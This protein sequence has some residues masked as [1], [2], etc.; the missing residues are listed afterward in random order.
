[1]EEVIPAPFMFCSETKDSENLNNNTRKQEDNNGINNRTNCKKENEE[2]SV[3]QI[4]SRENQSEKLKETVTTINM[5]CCSGVNDANILNDSCPRQPVYFENA[6][7]GY[8]SQIES[9]MS[10]M[11][12]GL[13][14]EMW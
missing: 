10:L 3:G 9:S 11:T 14:Y 4:A 6:N 5:T 7:N 2:Q 8:D 13:K 1:M 12:N